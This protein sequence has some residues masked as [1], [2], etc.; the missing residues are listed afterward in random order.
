MPE[1]SSSGHPPV[2]DVSV[3]PALTR[4]GALMRE[5]GFIGTKA[6]PIVVKVSYDQSGRPRRAVAAYQGGWHADLRLHKRGTYS[7][8]QSLRV[9]VSS[10]PPAAT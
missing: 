2:T 1:R 3:E 10:Q 8:N 9:R 4:I 5:A 7:L 6:D